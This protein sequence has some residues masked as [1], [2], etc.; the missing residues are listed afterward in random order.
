MAD[1]H[2]YEVPR[3]IVARL[4]KE[5]VRVPVPHTCHNETN[6]TDFKKSGLGG[7]L[8]SSTTTVNPEWSR[9]Q[10]V[11]KFN[12][13]RIWFFLPHNRFRSLPKYEKQIPD[14]FAIA[15]D[16]RT[17]FSRAVG[18]FILYTTAVCVQFGSLCNFF[19]R[20]FLWI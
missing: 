12:H 15:K 10:K 17:A 13:S 4:V 16:A 9:H 20:F 1:A 5:A 2:P 19:P 11:S 6:T 14:G 7:A 8:F 3:A 18:T